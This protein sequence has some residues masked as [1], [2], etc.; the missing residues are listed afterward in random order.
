MITRRNTR[1][2]RSPHV[3]GRGNPNS[4]AKVVSNDLPW[5]RLINREFQYICTIVG[6]GSQPIKGSTSCYVPLARWLII[7]V[8]VMACFFFLY[9]FGI[10]LRIICWF[11]F[12][13]LCCFVCPLKYRL[14]PASFV[15][16]YRWFL[17][18]YFDVGKLLRNGHQI[19]LGCLK[20][21]FNILK[22]FGFRPHHHVI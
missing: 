10:F 3:V 2:L 16:L 1:A 4:N 13:F 17:T 21:H 19:K 11:L 6:D 5:R 22:C 8:L 15:V 12:A 9:F 20:L 7:F 18:L 14:T